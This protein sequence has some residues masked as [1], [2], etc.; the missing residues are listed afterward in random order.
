MIRGR[1]IAPWLAAGLLAC[2]AETPVPHA[3]GARADSPPP[4]G[5]DTLVSRTIGA[6]GGTLELP[7]YAVVTISTGAL[8]ST[9]SVSLLSTASAQIRDD[10][11]AT[12]PL[13][14]PAIAARAIVLVVGEQRPAAAL[15]VT[16]T[17]PDNLRREMS[18]SVEPTAWA[19][20][21][22]DGGGEILDGF[23]RLQADLDG[24]RETLTVLLTPESFTRERRSDGLY[25]AILVVAA[26]PVVR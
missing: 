7:G 19:Q 23:V 2:A 24:A 25:E 4:T 17:T 11:E 21:W 22:Q 18:D 16:L 3:A 13:S 12:V 20:V 26:V 5:R 6:D 15:E 14:S 10:F 9:E 1:A 8:G